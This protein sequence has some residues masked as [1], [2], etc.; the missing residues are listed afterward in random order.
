MDSLYDS[1]KNK[2]KKNLSEKAVLKWIDTFQDFVDGLNIDILLKETIKSMLES[3]QNISNMLDYSIS[4]LNDF[5][6]VKQIEPFLSYLNFLE[7][8]REKNYFEIALKY[9]LAFE[10]NTTYIDKF[11]RFIVVTNFYD[12]ELLDTVNL[13]DV[14]L[15]PEI[16]GITAWI[17]GLRVSR[18][19]LIAKDSGDDFIYFSDFH[20][21]KGLLG[22]KL[23]SKMMVYLIDKIKNNEKYKNCGL[24]AN[25]V[26][27]ANESGKGFYRTFGFEAF[28]P[29]EQK[30]FEYD[31][32]DPTLD[33][34]EQKNNGKANFLAVIFPEKMDECMAQNEGKIP[35]IEIDGVKIDCNTDFSK[36]V[37]E[38]PK[39]L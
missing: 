1:I 13:D 23:G 21:R 32:A 28:D 38:V 36:R 33:P 35:Y 5:Q 11:I 2:E 24:Y 4:E 6:G 34:K 39:A 16:G 3:N 20:N 26:S 9:A 30:V 31:D 19:G 14:E 8:K 29:I 17:G 22:T 10:D 37:N 27:G 15:N 25:C 18:L 7:E 12:I